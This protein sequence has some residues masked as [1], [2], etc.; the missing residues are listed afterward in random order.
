MRLLCEFSQYDFSKTW[1]RATLKAMK[2]IPQGLLDKAI[3]RLK[4]E[5]QPD[6]IFL[7]GSHAWGTP[8]DNSDVDL[9]VIVPDSGAAHPPRPT[10]APLSARTP[11]AQRRA[12]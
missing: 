2:T 6:E 1:T 12:R 5:F 3:D 4:A 10:R 9:L 8:H 7:Y 11:F